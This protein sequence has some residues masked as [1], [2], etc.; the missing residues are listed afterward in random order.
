[1]ANQNWNAWT[2]N[3]HW[4]KLEWVNTR[5]CIEQKYILCVF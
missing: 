4:N 3:M 2:F 1:M 5:S